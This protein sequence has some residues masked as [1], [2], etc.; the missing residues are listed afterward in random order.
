[1]P[2]KWNGRRRI[3]NGIPETAD[4]AVGTERVG[5]QHEAAQGVR[6][7][8]RLSV[9]ADREYKKQSLPYRHNEV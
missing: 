2:Q 1:M 7:P 9:Y 3:K 8:A 4:E 6:S 5:I